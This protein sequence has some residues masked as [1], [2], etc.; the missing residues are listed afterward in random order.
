[1]LYPMLQFRRTQTA[2]PLQHRLIHPHV[3]ESIFR[4]LQYYFV[5]KAQH[6][7]LDWQVCPLTLAVEQYVPDRHPL[8]T[9]L[10]VR[11]MKNHL[12]IHDNR[13]PSLQL[14]SFLYTLLQ[15][16]VHPHMPQMQNRKI[17]LFQKN[18]FSHIT[19]APTR[20]LLLWDFQ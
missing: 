17:S 9:H 20:L 14:L 12:K 8:L 3:P 4:S 13:L 18:Q 15:F 5:L 6:P 19:C 16:E 1:M 10:D 7:L 11:R 2:V